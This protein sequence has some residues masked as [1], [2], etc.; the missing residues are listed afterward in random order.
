MA[1]GTVDEGIAKVAEDKGG[2]T[3]YY[4][5]YKALYGSD[6]SWDTEDGTD[7]FTRR[8]VGKRDIQF[9]EWL[10]WKYHCNFLTA[11]EKNEF[12]VASE[13]GAPYR[14]TT[15]KEIFP[16]LD[17]CHCVPDIDDA[18]FDYG[19]GKGS[20]LISFLDYGFKKV[21]GAEY[22]PKIYD[23]LMDNMQKLGIDTDEN[24]ELICGDAGKLD[25]ELDQY[26]WFYFFLPFDNR[27]FEKCMDSICRSYQRKKRKLHIISISPL[28]WRCIEDS[29]IFRL[30]NQF[31][32]DMR[33]RVVDVFETYE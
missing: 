2:G 18:I 24:V 23:V 25:T 16:I 31:T 12:E 13:H 33:Q 28:S 27:I 3:N 1:G 26:N 6:I 5:F 19:C 21:G 11:I 30:V 20:A 17:K 9:F 15:Q 10:E 29:G 8:K 14:C 4:D 32:V 7:A 22:E